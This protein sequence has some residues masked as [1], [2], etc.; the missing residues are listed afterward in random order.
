MARRSTAALLCL[1]FVAV[2]FSP[3]I[4]AVTVVRADP[5][6]MLVAGDF[7]DID[8]WAL[9]AERNDTGPAPYTSI[10]INSESMIIEHDRPE[11]TAETRIWSSSSSTDS[12]AATGQPDGGV[13][14]SNGPDI[15]VDGFDF[16]TTTNNLLLNVSL[17]FVFEIPDTLQDDEVNFIGL[18][19]LSSKI[20][21]RIRISRNLS[22]LSSANPATLSSK[23]VTTQPFPKTPDSDE[24][25]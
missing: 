20:C 15:R 14:I 8:Q 9:N 21:Q 16:G 19:Y 7:S 11:N 4:Q 12:T 24:R 17:V 2:L 1:L 10:S 22:E 13:A 3:T 6:E 25:Y 5:V 18:F 23:A